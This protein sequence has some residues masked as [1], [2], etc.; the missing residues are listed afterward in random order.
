MA[1]RSAVARASA[2]SVKRTTLQ[3]HMSAML[4][5]WVP[6]Y[7]RRPMSTMLHRCKAIW[8][9]SFMLLP[10]ALSC[11]DR[12][13]VRSVTPA[14]DSAR[15]VL[16]FTGVSPA[17]VTYRLSG[18]FTVRGL[19]SSF[20]ATLSTEDD[21]GAASIELDVPAGAYQV[22]LEP[23][24]QVRRTGST[25]GSAPEP[26]QLVNATLVSPNP[27]RIVVASGES[28][29]VAFRFRVGEDE[30][31]TRSGSIAI[32]ALFDEA[33]RSDCGAFGAPRWIVQWTDVPLR[34]FPER[35]TFQ[36]ALLPNGDFAFAYDELSLQRS[37]PSIGFQGRA[38]VVAH[39]LPPSGVLFESGPYFRV[40]DAGRP[41]LDASRPI[42]FHDIRA[43]GALAS[44]G[45][46]GELDVPLPFSFPLLG[47]SYVRAAVSSNGYV[48]LAPPFPTFDNELPHPEMGAL[49]A[50]FWDDLNP[51]AGGSVHYGMVDTC[52]E[53]CGGVAGGFAIVDS[54]GVCSGGTT[55][56]IPNAALDCAGVC[57]G[58][59]VADACGSCG[60]TIV[61]PAACPVGP[62]MIVDAQMLRQTIRQDFVDASADACLINEGCVTGSGRRRV[63]RFGTQIA[64][65]GN[66]DLVV[67]APQEG[68]PLWEFDECHSHFHFEHYAKYD[69]LVSGT[70]EVLPI[71]SKNGFCVLD[72]AT[73]DPSIAVNG[74]ATY[75]CGF[76]GI[77]VGCADVYGADLPCQWVDI[78]DVPPGNYQLRLTTNPDSA[79]PELR[80]DNNSASANI[81][82]TSD[83]VHVL[84]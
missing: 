58:T 48:G 41:E 73:W 78:T 30:F 60:G 50:P 45:D 39:S 74:C 21:A 69:L 4:R 80:F 17:G 52:Q 18:V 19:G 84:P 76:Q 20:L 25:T 61:E 1:G 32:V 7:I 16:A 35:F 67:G 64:N 11:S 15:L 42:A 3:R 5:V 36:A 65:I 14:T 53:D 9:A 63:V 29:A 77:G 47:E 57:G 31:D 62:D 55:G 28:E 38:G 10:A 56:R 23:G 40:N 22:L 83:A 82:I 70:G 27:L 37:S 81:E 75:T 71:G 24:F 68:N 79:I 54:C 13:V 66:R 8:F 72:L 33:E 44:M 6:F 2:G 46:D 12:D 34:E 49:L 59:L 26:V 51:S 43:T